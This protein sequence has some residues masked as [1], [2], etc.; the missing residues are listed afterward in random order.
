MRRLSKKTL[1]LKVNPNNPDKGKILQAAKVIRDGGL[2]AFPTE[3]VYGLAANLLKKASIDR[4]YEI[5]KRPRGKPFTVHISRLDII[6]EMRCEVTDK[7]KAL[8]DKFWPGP[9]TI[10]LN[11]KDGRDIGFRMPKN[12]VALELISASKVPIA[13][14][15]A[16][17]SGKAPPKTAEEVLKQLDGKI[18]IVLDSGPTNLGIES[19]VIDLTVT[20]PQIL[21]QGAVREKEIFSV[22][23]HG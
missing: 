5:K 20:P 19:T 18:D 15:S 7:A 11:S 12:R 2:V 4:L 22:I 23:D 10:I 14:P 16:N 6:N 3:T 21:R 8:I 17:I 13:A 9:L 1:I